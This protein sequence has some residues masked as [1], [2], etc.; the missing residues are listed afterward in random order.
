MSRQPIVNYSGCRI[1]HQN[2]TETAIEDY[3][4]MK[5]DIEDNSQSIA[6]NA[7][8]IAT[9]ATLSG[10]GSPE[11]VVPANNSRLYVDELAPQLY[12]NPSAGSLTGWVAI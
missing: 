11:G 7:S 1:E 8:E 6:S 2:W 9:Y 4:A 3:M 12:F 10:A 5:E